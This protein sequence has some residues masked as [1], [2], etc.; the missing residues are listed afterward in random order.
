MSSLGLTRML[1]LTISQGICHFFCGK[2]LNLTGQ[3]FN[4][5][6]N[7]NPWENIKI[8]FYLKD[9]HKIYWLQIINALPKTQKDITLKEK[10]NVK[11]L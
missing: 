5:N 4:D 9:S 7:I 10:E 2:N 3:L 1:K 6:G 11:N 8:E